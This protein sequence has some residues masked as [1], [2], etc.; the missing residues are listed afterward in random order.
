MVIPFIA[1]IAVII[2]IVLFAIF[3]GK[4]KAEGEDLGDPGARSTSQPLD[5]QTA[6]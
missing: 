3:S 6:G 1:V 4:K 5:H 2:A